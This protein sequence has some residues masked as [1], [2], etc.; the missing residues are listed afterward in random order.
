MKRR[1]QIE[2]LLVGS[3]LVNGSYWADLR[4]ISREDIEDLITRDI[5]DRL[6][7]L[8][9]QAGSERM[10]LEVLIKDSSQSQAVIM[11]AVEIVA[12]RTFDEGKARY[13]LDAFTNYYFRGKPYNP[14]DV[15]F[16]DYVTQFIRLTHGTT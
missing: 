16:S 1:E 15:R 14:T 4:C 13:N 7:D 9:Q 6:P 12:D 2:R 5:F 8:V 10:P 11:Q 3:V